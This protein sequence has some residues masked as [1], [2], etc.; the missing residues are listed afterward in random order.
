[1][2]EK[3]KKIQVAKIS[4][5]ITSIFVIFLSVTYAFIN[6]T[7]QGTKKQVITAGTLE[8]DLIEDENNITLTNA[9]P[10][11]DEVGMIQ[12][13]FTFRLKNKGTTNVNYT[14]KL[15]DITNEVVRKCSDLGE[16]TTSSPAEC[17]KV[18]YP[19]SL[20]EE[21]LNLCKSFYDTVTTE[22]ECLNANIEDGAPYTAFEDFIDDGI[23]YGVFADTR[24][25]VETYPDNTFEPIKLETSIVKYYLTKNGTGTPALLSTLTDGQVDSGT[26]AGGETI[27][28]TLRLWIDS[29]VTYNDEISGQSLSYRID[30]EVSQNIEKILDENGCEV[31]AETS[32]NAPELTSGMIPVVYDETGKTWKKADTSS[33][34]YNY[35]NQNWANAVTVVE[36]GTQTREYYQNAE[37]GIPID[38]NDINT[39]WVWIPRYSYT[40]RDTYGVQLVGGSVPSKITPGAIDIKFI[41]RN[42]KDSGT[43]KCETCADNWV[44]PEGFKFGDEELSGFWMAKFETTGSM[45]PDKQA[46][47]DEN[48]T[49]ADLTVLPN[50]SSVRNQNVSSFFYASRSMQNSSNANKYG[51]DVIGASSMDVHML[52]N[53]EWGIVAMLS[54]SKYGKYGNPNYEGVNKEVYQNKSSSYI[55]GSS[56]GTPSQET[57]NTQVTYDISDSGYG[58][59]TTGTIYGVYDM[60]GGAGEYVM[61]NYNNRSGKDTYFNSGFEGLDEY[62]N[63]IE[64]LQWPDSKYYD[65]YT[66]NIDSTGYKVGDAT[67]ETHGWYSDNPRFVSTS[68][69]WFARDFRY[70]S[71]EYGGIF[72]V[73]PGPGNKGD[74]ATFRLAIK[75]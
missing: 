18:E 50:L 35:S 70:D 46:C 37:A 27:E 33:E 38:I 36:S 7:L 48:C 3:Q 12:E 2:S 16:I 56:N 14:L 28:Y 17:R 34:W 68:S 1:M 23:Y 40:I 20:R 41:A 9:L 65:L 60:S 19:Q 42:Q 74:S 54:Q 44:T 73:Y 15:V 32:P 69:N 25:L 22:E 29:D 26:I 21:A 64:G 59:S 49:A 63:Q 53:T 24:T 62:V 5:F 75:P 45:T 39:M 57:A 72:S 66:S 31:L 6:L 47:T 4:V 52:K 58:A 51:F 11:Y 8:L 67:Y 13:P 71:D 55:T 61:G 10:M 43:G 30:V